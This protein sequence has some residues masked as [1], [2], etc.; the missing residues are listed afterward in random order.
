MRCGDYWVGVS[1]INPEGLNKNS[2]FIAGGSMTWPVYLGEDLHSLPKISLY[3][4][5]IT[6][7]SR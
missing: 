2:I 4:G 3:L 6:K 5:K 1:E 7:S